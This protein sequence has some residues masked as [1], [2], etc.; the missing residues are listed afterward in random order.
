MIFFN[1]HELIYPL[2][3]ACV[4]NYFK[5]TYPLFNLFVECTVYF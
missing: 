1:V 3:N 5:L 2:L 4:F